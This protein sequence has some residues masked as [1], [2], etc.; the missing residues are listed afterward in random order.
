M[1]KFEDIPKSHE[2][3][4][5]GY[6]GFRA[7]IGRLGIGINDL[8]NAAGLKPYFEYKYKGLNY[9]DLLN[10][11]KNKIYPELK[12]K[13]NLKKGE[14]PKTKDL[15]SKEIGYRGFVDKVRR[16]SKNKGIIHNA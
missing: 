4:K 15:E 2:I 16:V 11:F 10:L 1:N 7:A 9:N 8:I 14:A 13:L 6:R 3:D 5:I 12:H